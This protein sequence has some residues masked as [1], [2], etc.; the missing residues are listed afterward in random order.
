MTMPV[1]DRIVYE[2]DRIAVLVREKAA[3]PAPT[4]PPTT[5]PPTSTPASPLYGMVNGARKA[6]GV[7]MLARDPEAERIAQD[8]AEELGRTDD[9]RHNPRIG[10]LLS[11]PW[12]SNGENIAWGY[13]SE[14]VV[15]E[16]WMDS[17]G[18]RRNI[19]D[20]RYTDLGVGLATNAAGRR[21][22]V[23]V[24]VDRLA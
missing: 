16:A 23:E 11:A 2:D 15:H 20:P 12:F 6:A 9:F 3:P 13:T 4:P 7:G 22:W 17:P 19:E 10:G 8:W 21:Y 18:H 5:P 1:T 14:A 24:F